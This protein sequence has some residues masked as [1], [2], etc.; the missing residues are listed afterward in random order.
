MEKIQE[1]ILLKRVFFFRGLLSQTGEKASTNQ[2]IKFAA[3]AS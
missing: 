2:E 3:F 1:C